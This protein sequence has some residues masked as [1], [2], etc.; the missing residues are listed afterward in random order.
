MLPFT[1]GKEVFGVPYKALL[2]SE[3]NN[4]Y[5]SFMFTSICFFCKHLKE[6]SL[7]EIPVKNP[8]CMQNERLLVLPL[9]F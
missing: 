5:V 2:D 8:P 9:T 7:H 4:G 1:A 6:F 3:L